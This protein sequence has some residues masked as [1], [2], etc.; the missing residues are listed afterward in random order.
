MTTPNPRRVDIN[1]VMPYLLAGGIVLFQQV[2]FGVPL[3]IF[4]RG[5][6]IGLLTALI[7]LGMA[8]T[9]RSNRFINFAQADM[10][11]IPVVLIVML[12]TAW[13]WPYLLAVPVGVIAALALGAVVEL[14]VI[15]R[16]FKAP[17]LL[18]TVAIA[19]AVAGAQCAGDPPAA[20]VGGRLPPPRPA[21]PRTVRAGVLDRDGRV[22]RERSH[23]DDRRPA[24]AR[25]PRRLPAAEQ[26]GHRHQGQRRQ[27]RSRRPAR[28]AGEAAADA[29]LGGRLAARLHRH[30]PAGRHHRPAGVRRARRS[31]CCCAR[32]PR[33]CSG[34]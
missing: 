1:R 20:P 15:R 2:F 21:P 25:R 19:R 16:F 11:T 4:V 9:Y 32:S 14:A 24:G 12:M 7:A 34:G 18:L 10:G 23:R 13:G 33:W 27:R 29:R 8:L 22:R 30:L 6:L 5:V 28:R 17:R 3:G 26:R 31:A